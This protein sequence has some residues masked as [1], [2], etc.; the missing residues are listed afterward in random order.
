[1]AS[2]EPGASGSSDHFHEAV[3]EVLSAP[4][5]AAESQPG[6]RFRL[7]G[8]VDA[9]HFAVGDRSTKLI[10]VAIT[11]VTYPERLAFPFIVELQQRFAPT[12]GV[13]AQACA[14]HSLDG[15]V[16]ADFAAICADFD[17][18]ARKDKVAKVAKQV[19]DVKLQMEGNIHLQL[20]NMQKATVIKG[21]AEKLRRTSELFAKQ[22]KT[23]KN[24]ERWRYWKLKACSAC[25]C[26]GLIAFLVLYFFG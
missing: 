5:F 20:R 1:M 9:F 15:E 18:P 19:E 24:R 21:K 13:R 14:E 23:L 11:R 3:H 25:A 26:L 8:D 4:D 16:R 10:Y 7:E 12:F 2:F 17:D 22:A 6:C